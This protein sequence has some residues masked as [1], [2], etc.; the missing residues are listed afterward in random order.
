MV[1]DNSSSHPKLVRELMT[2]GVLTCSQTTPVK[3]IT[4]GILEKDLE[5]VVVLDPEGHAVGIVGKDQ[6]VQAYAC[7]DYE[8]LNAE[9][10]MD[11]HVPQIPP[12]IP[13]SAA[14]QLMLDQKQRIVYLTH[15][16]GG[17]VY[18]AAYLSY[19]HFLRHIQMEQPEDLDDL[20]IDA[21]RQSPLDAFIA[22]R[23]AAKKEKQ[24]QNTHLK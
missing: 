16:A 11:D 2:V 15:H 21:D 9:D 5:A 23:E 19:K 12:D 4:K 17:I 3:T 13:L 10:I 14:A 24:N 7:R 18:P 1:K 8:N 20:G 6:L 22:R